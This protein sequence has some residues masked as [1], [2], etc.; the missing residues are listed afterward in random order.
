[1]QIVIA[2]RLSVSSEDFSAEGSMQTTLGSDVIRVGTVSVSFISFHTNE[3][4]GNRLELELM[5]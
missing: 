3:H 4:I 1:M 2:R 5:P